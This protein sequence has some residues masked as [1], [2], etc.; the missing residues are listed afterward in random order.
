MPR[1]WW[2]FWR[3]SRPQ[4]PV[5][6]VLYTRSHCPLCDKAAEF[7]EKERQRLGLELSYVDI[8][9]DPA[10]TEKHGDWIPVVEVNGQIRFRGSINPVLWKRLMER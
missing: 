5:R 6:V 9:G 4:C 3:W 2:Q 7:L 1:K 10:Q 8:A